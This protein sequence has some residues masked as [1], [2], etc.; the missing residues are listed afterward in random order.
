MTEIQWKWWNTATPELHD[1]GLKI[2]DSHVK[3]THLHTADLSKNLAI[4]KQVKMIK[5]QTTITTMSELQSIVGS[6]VGN[7]IHITQVPA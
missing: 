1:A 4:T 5:T 3:V 7:Q 2:L 6:I